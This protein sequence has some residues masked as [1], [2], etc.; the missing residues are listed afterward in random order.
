GKTTTARVLAKSLN[1][2]KGPTLEP[3]NQCSACEEIAAGASIDV[4]EIDAASNTGVDNVRQVIIETVSLTPSRDRYKIF[5]IDEVHMLSGG[6][7]NALLKTLEEPPAHVLFVLA[8]TEVHKIPPTIFSRCQRFRFRPVSVDLIV[9]TLQKVAEAENI[10]AE[11]RAVEL[12]AKAAGGGLR[13]AL[14]LLDQANALASGKIK[15]E[16]VLDLVGVLPEEFL[17]DLS[18]ALLEKDAR[19]LWKHLQV[20]YGEGYESVRIGR[21]LRDALQRAYLFKLKV[22]ESLENPWR[23]MTEPHSAESFSFILRQLNRA[24]DEMRWSEQP[25]MILELCLFGLLEAAYDLK[26][27][28]ERLERLEKSGP[29][30]TAENSPSV[31]VPG[32]GGLDADD[33]PAKAG[34]GPAAVKPDD[35]V[36]W[37]KILNRARSVKP[38]LASYLENAHL[39]Q[40][41]NSPDWT[42]RFGNQFQLKGSERSA[43]WIA[44]ALKELTGQEKAVRFVLDASLEVLH[45]TE[46]VPASTAGREGAEIGAEDP[47]AKDPDV[48]KVMEFFPGKIHKD[49]SGSA[50]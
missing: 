18:R 26:D 1:C 8:T 14:S 11:P 36:L 27:W 29:L 37:K 41:P 49:K 12:L 48:K 22:A 16:T 33:A 45:G 46:E 34:A 15:R 4:L 2:K 23:E 20:L 7:F 38:A 28:V 5:I 32:R 13:D 30:K 17:I 19:K 3:C 31:A 43:P 40:V 24:L 10:E 35:D 47:V 42:V 21:D 50:E 9:R 39:S 25:Q 6:A 44:Q